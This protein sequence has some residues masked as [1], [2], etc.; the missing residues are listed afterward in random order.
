MK[1]KK[2]S[3]TLD[4]FRRKADQIQDVEALKKIA[5]SLLA[6]CHPRNEFLQYGNSSM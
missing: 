5:G 6:E 1:S 4:D 2:M 3:L